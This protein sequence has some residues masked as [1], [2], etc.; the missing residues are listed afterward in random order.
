MITIA[1]KFIVDRCEQC[2]RLVLLNLAKDKSGRQMLLC[3]DCISLSGKRG[4]TDP[5]G[6]I[7]WPESENATIPER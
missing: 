3:R 7:R 2:G 6:N 4:L 5:L 1:R